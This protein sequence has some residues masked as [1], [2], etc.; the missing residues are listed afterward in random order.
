MVILVIAVAAIIASIVFGLAIFF[1]KSAYIVVQT[2]AKNASPDNWYLSVSHMNGDAAY[3]NHSLAT[4][5]GMPVDFQFTTPTGSTVIPLPDPA[6][7]PEAWNPGDTLFVY[8]KSGLLGVTK[9]ETT[10]RKG[11]GLPTGV[12]RFDVVDKTDD[13][14]IYT[15][16]TGVGVA[17]P[18]GSPTPVIKYTI[19]SSVS[20]VGGSISP[21]GTTNVSFGGSQSYAITPISGYHVF[22]VLVDGGSVGNVT[23]YQ[24]TNVVS[25]HTISASFAV[26]TYTITSSVSG[27]GGS[28]SPSGTTTVP[29]GGSQFYT[30]IPAS[31]YHIN[32]VTVD[33]T[34]VGTVSSYQFTNVVSN[35]VIVA[36]FA[37]N[38]THTISVSEHP[39]GLGVITPAGSTIT[40]AYGANQ[41]FHIAANSNKKIQS[42]K[43]DGVEQ[44]SAEVQTYDYTFLNVIINHSFDVT[45]DP[46]PP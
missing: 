3:L 5:E 31:G 37:Q 30:I 33:A 38:T 27:T 13:V 35:R 24:F 18:T 17:E 28:I 45:Y 14:L 44:L 42:V 25:S 12:W 4:N 19:T 29:S 23:T 41:G 7:G 1:P 21:S 10:A 36:S 2:E 20:G 8:N 9:N 26:N 15:K 43:V 34:S 39:G 46:N 11:T 22:D 16:N 32:D 6:D 40:V